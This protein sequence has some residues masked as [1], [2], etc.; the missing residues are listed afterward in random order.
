MS[1][2]GKSFR[3]RK[4]LKL[5]E[6]LGECKVIEEIFA[7]RG[8]MGTIVADHSTGKYYTSLS[9]QWILSE[10]MIEIGTPV[11]I[12]AHIEGYIQTTVIVP[13]GESFNFNRHYFSEDKEPVFD[14]LLKGI[15]EFEIDLIKELREKK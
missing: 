12:T 7:L 4:D 15:N 6:V 3:I 5:H 11:K 13:D 9:K 14:Q 8:Q 10:E 2:I 1:N